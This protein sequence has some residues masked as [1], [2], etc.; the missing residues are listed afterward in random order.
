VVIDVDGEEEE[1]AVRSKINSRWGMIW[2]WQNLKDKQYGL[3]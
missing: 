2:I 3:L 1:Q